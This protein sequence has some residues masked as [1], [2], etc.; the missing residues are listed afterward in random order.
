MLSLRGGKYNIVNLPV[1]VLFTG[2]LPKY[3][4][5]PALS[6]VYLKWSTHYR[7]LILCIIDHLR[8]PEKLGTLAEQPENEK[9][10]FSKAIQEYLP[11]STASDKIPI[12]NCVIHE[13]WNLLILQEVSSIKFSIQIWQVSF[14]KVLQ[15]YL[16]FSTANGTLPI[17]SY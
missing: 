4:R 14:S 2:C 7:I 10:W 13:Q 11:V 1:A 8:Y 17:P 12:V 15:D 16:P 9:V 5:L 6:L 3:A